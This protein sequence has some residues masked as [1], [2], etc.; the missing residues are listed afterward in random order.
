LHAPGWKAQ[1]HHLVFLNIGYPGF[2]RRQ[3]ARFIF[4]RH[5]VDGGPVIL[6]VGLFQFKCNYG[7]AYIFVD[8]LRYRPGVIGPGQ[9]ND[10]HFIGVWTRFN[11]RMV[12]LCLGGRTSPDQQKKGKQQ[13]RHGQGYLRFYI[14]ILRLWS[15]QILKG[16]ID[17]NL[18]SHKEKKEAI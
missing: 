17:S 11:F 6:R 12:V 15:S 5:L 2:Q 13:L 8:D 3:E 14:E 4:P 9:I 18:L 7:P 10:Q 16:C 1:K